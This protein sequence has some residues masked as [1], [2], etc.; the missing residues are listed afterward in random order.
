MRGAKGRR[1]SREGR[2][3][4]GLAS[5]HELSAS[6][7]AWL[8]RISSMRRH[9]SYRFYRASGARSRP[10][11]PTQEHV[12]L[13]KHRDVAGGSQGVAACRWAPRSPYR[14]VYEVYASTNRHTH[15]TV[16]RRGRGTCMELARTKF[17]VV[18]YGISS[19]IC[20]AL[21][22]GGEAERREQTLQFA[23][24]V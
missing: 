3:D 6:N 10:P 23:S 7:A 4:A 14:T 11:P 8:N 21:T 20:T 16:H 1:A 9:D 12:T 5:L 2:V 17:L 24:R 15:F 22:N 19:V 13:S 18:K